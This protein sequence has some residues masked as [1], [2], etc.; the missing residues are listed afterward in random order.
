MDLTVEKN[1]IDLMLSSA[2]E[3]EWNANCDKVK[4]SNGGYYPEF[5]FVAII[6]SGIIITVSNGWACIIR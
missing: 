6:A 4:T 3:S 5:W 2:N 1:V